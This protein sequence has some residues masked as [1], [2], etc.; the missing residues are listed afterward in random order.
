[1]K[2]VIVVFG[3][4]PEAIKMAPLILE[5]KKSKIFETVIC[6]TGQH[7]EMLNQVLNVFDIKVDYNLSIMKKNQGLSEITSKILDS[8][9]DV[10]LKEKPDI[11]LVH[12]D[13]TTTFSTSLV[14]FYNNVMIGHIEAGLRT[15]DISSPFPEEFN[16]Q[17]VGLITDYHFAA[18]NRAAQNLI[19]EGKN[20]NKIFVTGNT[21]I[22]ALKTTVNSS[23]SHPELLW[24][25]NNKLILVTVHRRE[26]IGKP[27]QN[28]AKSILKIVNNNKDVKV[29][30]PV[31]P[32]PK[33]KNIITSLLGN[34]N[35]IHL[36]EPL[37][38]ID[39]H[40]FMAHSYFI[41]S[42]SGGIQE[43]APS[44]GKPVLVLRDTTERPEGVEAG[45]L[46]LVGTEIVN[47][48]KEAENLLK[49]KKE[50]ERM[51]NSINPYGDGNASKRIV[52]ILEDNV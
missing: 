17:A 33:I 51:S 19:F 27:L 52:D 43:E 14:C 16:R 21:V 18:T 46:K 1:M 47:I 8:I 49:N 40:N 37:E 9:E 39:F 34:H 28:I 32:N 44:L 48:V 36:I 5:M 6:V 11:V 7:K 45:T 38:V 25:K 10:L 13:T 24:A 15:N 30:F 26:N 35:Q 23:Y 12:G 41:M 20:K 42:D 50:Y 3:T 2:K 31:H 22:D 29:V 4:R